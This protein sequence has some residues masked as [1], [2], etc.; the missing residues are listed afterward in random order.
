MPDVM[1]IE[2]TKYH[3]EDPPV[4]VQHTVR[5]TQRVEKTGKTRLQRW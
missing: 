2:N 1:P 3:K 4:S 5:N